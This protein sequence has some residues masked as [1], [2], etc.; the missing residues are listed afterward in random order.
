M[1]RIFAAVVFALTLVTFAVPASLLAAPQQSQQELAQP[2]NIN[3]ADFGQ[4]VKLPGIGKVTA[5]RIVAYRQANGPF[6]SVDDLV[7]V[8]GVGKKTLEKL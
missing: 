8:K 1:K 6:A 4:L 3:T 2:I 5:E 7:K